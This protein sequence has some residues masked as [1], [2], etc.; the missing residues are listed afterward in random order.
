MDKNILLNDKKMQNIAKEYK[1]YILSYIHSIYDNKVK[2]NN[3]GL[4]I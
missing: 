2:I 1:S 4:C 3:E